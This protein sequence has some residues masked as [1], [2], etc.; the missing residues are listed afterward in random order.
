MKEVLLSVEFRKQ[1]VHLTYNK[2]PSLN[3]AV[4]RGKGEGW[5]RASTY[6]IGSRAQKH[7]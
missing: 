4:S 3:S 7:V 1:N 2:S 6:P 5:R